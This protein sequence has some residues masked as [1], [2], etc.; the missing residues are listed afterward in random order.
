MNENAAFQN[1]WVTSR[2][3]AYNEYSRKQESAV[4]W[5]VALSLSTQ[6]HSYVEVVTSGTSEYNHIW[7]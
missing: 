6:K 1:L 5:I 7:K 2:F 3:I 4:G